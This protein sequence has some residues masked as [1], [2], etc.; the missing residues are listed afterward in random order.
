MSLLQ[1][2]HEETSKAVAGLDK[3][4]KITG[5]QLDIIAAYSEM[6]I[7]YGAESHLY[8]ARLALA[9]SLGFKSLPIMDAATILLGGCPDEQKEWGK[10][11]DWSW[12]YDHQAPPGAPM[13]T[14]K[15]GGPPTAYYRKRLSAFSAPAKDCVV[16]GKA[17][18]LRRKIPAGVVLAM[19]EVAALRLFNCFSVLAPE[20]M[21]GDKPSTEPDPILFATIAMIGRNGGGR[22]FLDSKSFFLAKWDEKVGDK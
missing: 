21:W 2:L 7:A 19:R 9:E 17:N 6:G 8:E 11:Q 4:S 10:R 3:S 20:S 12:F 13:E 1:T 14:C 16:F 18:C 15:W 5:E 22:G